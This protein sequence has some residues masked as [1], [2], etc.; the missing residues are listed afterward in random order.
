MALSNHFWFLYVVSVLF[1]MTKL[2]SATKYLVLILTL[3]PAMEF[4]EYVRKEV[5]KGKK[6]EKFSV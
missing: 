1:Y 3:A 2:V 5:K 4:F 6:A